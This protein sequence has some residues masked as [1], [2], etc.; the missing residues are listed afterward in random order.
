MVLEWVECSTKGRPVQSST[1]IHICH[2]VSGI[3]GTVN[4]TGD[5]GKLNTSSPAYIPAMATTTATATKAQ[6]A[7]SITST[8]KSV[9]LLPRLAVEKKNKALVPRLLSQTFESGWIG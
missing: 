2:G 8:E 7:P 6:A 3:N 4:R 9:P 1:R 5:A